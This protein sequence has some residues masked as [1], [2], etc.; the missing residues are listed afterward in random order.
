MLQQA[1]D[2]E[3]NPTGPPRLA[4]KRIILQV[5]DSSSNK[6]SHRKAVT[7]NK[8]FGKYEIDVPEP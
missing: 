7:G 8:A 3:S 5:H 2:F 6:K 4:E 1:S